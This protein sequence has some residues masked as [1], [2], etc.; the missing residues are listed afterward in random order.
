MRVGGG[1]VA[2]DGD[3]PGVAG[4]EVNGGRAAMGLARATC[5]ETAFGEAGE[6]VREAAVGAGETGPER[7]GPVPEQAEAGGDEDGERGEDGVEAPGELGG[8]E[9]G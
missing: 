4:G 5:G 2:E 9:G 6:K 3:E 8:G 1:L 7:D